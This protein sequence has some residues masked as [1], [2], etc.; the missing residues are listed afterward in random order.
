MTNP[1]PGEVPDSVRHFV[2][3]VA[4]EST[5]SD[6]LRRWALSLLP[7]CRVQTSLADEVAKLLIGKPVPIWRQSDV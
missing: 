7:T 4:L 3:A 6:S 2:L 1:K 5:V